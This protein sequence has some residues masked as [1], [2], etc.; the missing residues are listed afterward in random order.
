MTAPYVKTPIFQMMSAQFG[1]VTEILLQKGT[2]MPWEKLKQ[3]GARLPLC[4]QK[5]FKRRSDSLKDGKGVSH[6]GGEV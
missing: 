6:Q 1:A 4:E 3:G 2:V 5:A